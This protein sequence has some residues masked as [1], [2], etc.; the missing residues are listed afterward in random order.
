MGLLHSNRPTG[1]IP[2]HIGGDPL[3]IVF[4]DKLR[5]LREK[6]HLSRDKLAALSGLSPG[7]IYRLETGQ[8]PRPSHNT[9][10]KLAKALMVSVTDFDDEG[11][12]VPDPVTEI[13]AFP[14]D[15]KVLLRDY[16]DDPEVREIHVNLLAMRALDPDELS[17]VL[18]YVKF[19]VERL[20]RIR[21]EEKDAESRRRAP[22]EPG[23]SD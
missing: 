17:R 21:Q 13:E 3:A 12:P 4:G 9:I 5:S 6:R 7:Y 19:M 11:A 20:M 2:N 16:I 23:P 22:D 14:D 18:E 15:L 10:V 8:R 1:I